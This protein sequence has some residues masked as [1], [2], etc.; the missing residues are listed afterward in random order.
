[1]LLRNCRMR[2]LIIS[3]LTPFL[4]LYL[5]IGTQSGALNALF[6]LF[7]DSG[8]YKH[9]ASKTVTKCHDS[10]YDF[11]NAFRH[12]QT[13]KRT[14]GKFP[15]VPLLVQ[16]ATFHYQLK[17]FTLSSHII[18][19]YWTPLFATACCLDGNPLP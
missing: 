13:Y 17:T 10:N 4:F 8:F 7:E 6:S 2:L 11:L 16:L 5:Q 15:P 3:E 9:S 1:M 14:G 18:K 19:F 12:L